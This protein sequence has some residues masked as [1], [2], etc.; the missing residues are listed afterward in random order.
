MFQIPWFF[1][2]A[3]ISTFYE[4]KLQ[5]FCEVIMGVSVQTVNYFIEM[6]EDLRKNY[7]R[8][9]YFVATSAFCS[10]KCLSSC[11]CPPK[12]TWELTIYFIITLEI[13]LWLRQKNTNTEYTGEQSMSWSRRWLGTLSSMEVSFV[14]WKGKVQKLK[15]L[16]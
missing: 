13:T 7:R 1:K 6:S 12:R 5:R 8:K 10:L 15:S 11:S 16:L 14:V 4:M 3:S 2:M 9:F